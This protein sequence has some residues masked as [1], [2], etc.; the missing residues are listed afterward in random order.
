MKNNYKNND[1][2]HRKAMALYANSKVNYFG[3]NHKRD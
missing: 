3:V 2:K 1:Q